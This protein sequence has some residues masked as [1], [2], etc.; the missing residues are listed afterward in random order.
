MCF[1]LKPALMTSS[2]T[3]HWGFIMIF[4]NRESI[5][6]H[7]LTHDCYCHGYLQCTCRL[8]FK[9]WNS[10]WSF[11]WNWIP[12]QLQIYPLHKLYFMC[13]SLDGDADHLPLP[14]CGGGSDSNAERGEIERYGS[15]GRQTHSLLCEL[16]KTTPTEPSTRQTHF[17]TIIVRMR[18]KVARAAS[19][20]VSFHFLR[21]KER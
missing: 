5:M 4:R 20:F 10:T 13:S 8:Y 15:P 11:S 3:L 18:A 12:E 6:S 9:I 19:A 1:P 21:K 16:D 17:C 14:V 2:S 7:S